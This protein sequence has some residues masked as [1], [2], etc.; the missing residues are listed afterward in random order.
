MVHQ[1]VEVHPI[2]TG[3][4]SP[5]GYLTIDVVKPKTKVEQGDPENKPASIS[6]PDRNGP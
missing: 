3:G 2:E 1:I 4:S 6:R 5:S